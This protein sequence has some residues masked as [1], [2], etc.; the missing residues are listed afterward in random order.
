MTQHLQLMHLSNIG[1]SYPMTSSN[2]VKTEDWYSLILNHQV[3]EA[4]NEDFLKDTG[5][6]FPLFCNP[7]PGLVGTLCISAYQLIIASPRSRSS[8][9]VKKVQNSIDEP[10]LMERY[11]RCLRVS[12]PLSCSNS[13]ASWGSQENEERIVVTSQSASSTLAAAV[14]ANNNNNSTISSSSSSSH[15]NNNN[16]NNNNNGSK[17]RCTN[18]F[19]KHWKGRG[20]GQRVIL[21]NGRCTLSYKKQ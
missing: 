17:V 2:I 20:V 9:Q 7:G 13:D 6:I 3:T 18:I 10:R 11:L 5:W 16:S 15:N 4:G 21:T 19:I 1:H 14:T 8:P 12:V